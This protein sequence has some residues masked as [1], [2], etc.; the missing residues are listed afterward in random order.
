MFSASLS[1]PKTRP[2][3]WLLTTAGPPLLPGLMA[4]L[5]WMTMPGVR[6]EYWPKS[7]RDTTPLVTE[8]SRPPTGKP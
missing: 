1:R 3:I 8:R 6:S 2:I 5:T 7:M 4:A